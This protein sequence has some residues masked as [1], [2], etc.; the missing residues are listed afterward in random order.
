MVEDVIIPVTSIENCTKRSDF[1]IKRKDKYS[2]SAEE[3]F[4]DTFGIHLLSYHNRNYYVAALSSNVKEDCRDIE[5]ED[6]IIPNDT[7][8]KCKSRNDF[9]IIKHSIVHPSPQQIFMDTF[10]IHLSYHNR[11]Y[12]V[13][14]LS[15][16]VKEDC[17]DIEI[18]DIII[19]NDTIEKCKS[20]N[21]FSIIKHSIAN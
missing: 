2:K 13:A 9:S 19:P 7:I 15:S 12:Y 21:D 11:N 16:N 8:E 1:S 5:I 10:G 14:A 17:R 3:I 4:M 20:R 18:G 6:I